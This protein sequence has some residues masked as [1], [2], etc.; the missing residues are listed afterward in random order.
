MPSVG[1]L[2][3]KGLCITKNSS[4]IFDSYVGIF[5]KISMK[6]LNVR[7]GDS[8]LTFLGQKIGNFIP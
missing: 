3:V 4:E 2:K 7:F 1:N 6:I 8:N 5:S